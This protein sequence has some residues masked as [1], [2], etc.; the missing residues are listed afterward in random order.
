[1]P[2]FLDEH[3]GG[4]GL[5]AQRVAALHRRDVEL[6]ERWGVRFRD[7]W[8]EPRTGSFF[9]LAEGPTREAVEA[10][11]R[12]AHGILAERIVEVQDGMPAWPPGPPGDVDEGDE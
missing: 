4:R 7:Y 10:V 3:G 11:H 6:Q 2:L 12:A 9:C 5:T 8:F 1:M